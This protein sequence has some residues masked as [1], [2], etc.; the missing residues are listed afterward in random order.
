[1]EAFAGL[2]ELAPLKY[3]SGKPVCGPHWCDNYQR[4][5]DYKLLQCSIG[6]CIHALSALFDLHE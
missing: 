3:I 2:L 6:E 5:C 4:Y 1:M